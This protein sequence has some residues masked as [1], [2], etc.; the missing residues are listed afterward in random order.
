MKE[1]KNKIIGKL[2]MEKNKELLKLK[3]DISKNL[4]TDM[5]DYYPI[6]KNS[7]I[8]ILEEVD[9][10]FSPVYQFLHLYKLLNMSKK[11]KEEYKSN[12]HNQIYDILNNTT[13][14]PNS[15]SYKNWLYW[16]GI[17]IIKNDSRT[18]L[19]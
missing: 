9:I 8:N 1:N 4:T 6:I 3:N 17:N 7:E 19:Y 16:I 12:R 2:L 15:E 5:I 14:E 18:F 11:C 10:D 13:I